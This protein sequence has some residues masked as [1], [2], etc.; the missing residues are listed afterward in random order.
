MSFISDYKHGY[1][2]EHEFKQC[3]ARE[4]RRD[5]YEREQ[6]G[7]INV[8][9]DSYLPMDCD[10]KFRDEDCAYCIEYDECKER[11]SS[12]KEREQK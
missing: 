4:N 7:Q 10:G 11:F 5:R 1:M 8:I 6:M 3:C 9:P 2:E 12:E